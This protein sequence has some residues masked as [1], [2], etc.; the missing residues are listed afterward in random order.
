M[1]NQLYKRN[2]IIIFSLCFVILFFIG[3][4]SFLIP[5]TI[6]TLEGQ[7]Q[8]RQTLLEE[9]EEISVLKNSLAVVSDSAK[10]VLPEQ[11]ATSLIFENIGRIGEEYNMLTS[12]FTIST[13]NEILSSLFSGEIRQQRITMDTLGTKD[14]TKEFVKR[15]EELVPLIEVVSFRLAINEENLTTGS[16]ILQTFYRDSMNDFVPEEKNLSQEAAAIIDHPY[17]DYLFPLET[18]IVEPSGVDNITE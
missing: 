18:E 17:L 12:N 6:Q 3:S 11:P 1:F 9:R 8:E 4:I 15:L 2:K 7:R 16:F 10:L 13:P 14:A 5:A